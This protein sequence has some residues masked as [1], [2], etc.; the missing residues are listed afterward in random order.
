VREIVVIQVGQ[1]GN[2]IGTRFWQL[3]LREFERY[4][5][6]KLY[7]EALSSFFRNVDCTSAI[8]V[9]CDLFLVPVVTLSLLDLRLGNYERVR[10]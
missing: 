1:C 6:M 7:D 8:V 3:A 9:L 10:C 5:R 2:Q 4:N